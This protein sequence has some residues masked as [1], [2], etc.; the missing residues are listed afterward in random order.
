MRYELKLER[1]T[2][3]A[4][5][6]DRNVHIVSA[7]V[8]WH[9]NRPLTVSGQLA[10]KW[11]DETSARRRQFGPTFEAELLGGSHDLRH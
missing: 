3:R 6:F 1:D 5:P 7:H 8:N 9:P 10:G 11:V 2:G 4:D